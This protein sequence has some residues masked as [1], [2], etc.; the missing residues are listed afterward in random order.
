MEDIICP[1][2]NDIIKAN[3]SWDFIDGEKHKIT[4]SCGCKF[5]VII[6]RPIEYYIPESA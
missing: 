6:E 4:C 5:L 3:D 2:C 1:K